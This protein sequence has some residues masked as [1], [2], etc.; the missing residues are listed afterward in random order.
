MATTP[1]TP[2]NFNQFEKAML[3]AAV[4]LQI[5]STERAARTYSDNGKP[6]TARTLHNEVENLMGLINKIRSIET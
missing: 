5:K 2:I 3:I 4:K 1:N 6:E